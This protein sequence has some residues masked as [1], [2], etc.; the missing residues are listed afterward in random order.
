MLCRAATAQAHTVYCVEDH[1]SSNLHWTVE[2]PMRRHY[3]LST[4]RRAPPKTETPFTT[5]ATAALTQASC[6]MHISQRPSQ[7]RL[8]LLLAAALRQPLDRRTHR[9]HCVGVCD[10]CKA[11]RP[12][13]P[14]EC[15]L[16]PGLVKVASQACFGGCPGTTWKLHRLLHEFLQAQAIRACQC[17]GMHVHK[18]STTLK[19]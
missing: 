6:H 7:L 8:R 11:P 19:M 3:N 13:L 16:Q 5:A 15:I 1:A 9:R 12:S 17:A 4:D 14:C 18:R 10:A 2:S